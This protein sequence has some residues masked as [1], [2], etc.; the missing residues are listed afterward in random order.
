VELCV[1][2][3][4]RGPKTRN[5]PIADILLTNSD[6]DH[7]LGLL[8]KRQQADPLVVY[9]TEKLE[10]CS[11]GSMRFLDDFTELNGER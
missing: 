10:W 4:P 9:A 5:S 1:S 11:I 6:L 7:C 8:L 3:L 2:Q